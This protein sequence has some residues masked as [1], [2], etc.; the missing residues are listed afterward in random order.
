M[1]LLFFIYIICCYGEPGLK[2]HFFERIPFLPKGLFGTTRAPSRIASISESDLPSTHTM[3]LLSEPNILK[4]FSSIRRKLNDL[5]ESTHVSNEILRGPIE[6]EMSKEIPIAKSTEDDIQKILDNQE[7]ENHMNE[8]TKTE[9]EIQKTHENSEMHN[10]IAVAHKI[11]SAIQSDHEQQ[12]LD[13][14]IPNVENVINDILSEKSVPDP[15]ENQDIV[16]SIY[17]TNILSMNIN[18]TIED[19]S[20]VPKVSKAPLVITTETMNVFIK[21]TEQPSLNIFNST[22][23]VLTAFTVTKQEADKPVTEETLVTSPSEIITPTV[24]NKKEEFSPTAIPSNNEN[25]KKKMRR[26]K[27]FRKQFRQKSTPKPAVDETKPVAEQTTRRPMLR[28][29]VKSTPKPADETKL[30]EEIEKPTRRPMLRKLV[31]LSKHPQVKEITI[32]E[33]PNPRKIIFRK[34][35]A[36]NQRRRLTQR[37]KKDPLVASLL[38]QIKNLN[39]SDFCK[40]QKDENSHN[41]CRTWFR[42]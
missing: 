33:K 41:I 32:E 10:M 3:D 5:R 12:P 29:L 15:I 7:F 4:S 30:D 13:N 18:K 38:S 17:E 36:N 37:T 22:D 23:L 8:A 31:K 2:N 6:I 35:L 14:I 28:K 19:A 25:E 42:R 27:F 11:E 16:D 40:E 26:R 24:I 1:L 39:H 9:M 20:E 34:G 21:P